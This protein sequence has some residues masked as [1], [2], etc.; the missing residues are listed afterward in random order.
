MK[1]HRVRKQMDLG[2]VVRAAREEQGLTQAQLAEAL[3]VPRDYIVDLENSKRTLQMT[4]L[5]RVLGKLGIKMELEWGADEE[6]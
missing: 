3:V 4:R 2:A 6:S 5:F 1:Q